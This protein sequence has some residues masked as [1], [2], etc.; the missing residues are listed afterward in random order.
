MADVYFIPDLKINIISLGQ[1]TESGCD[2]RMKDDYLTLRERDGRLI[3]SA[4][5]SRNRLYKVLIDIVESRCRQT[6]ALLSYSV[7]WH[8]W[9]GHVEEIQ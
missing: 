5:R 8:S 6:E 9:L 3:T 2:I 1:A 7:K 4:K